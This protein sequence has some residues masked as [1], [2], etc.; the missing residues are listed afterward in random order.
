MVTLLLPIIFLIGILILQVFTGDLLSASN[1]D[2]LVNISIDGK[3]VAVEDVETEKNE[4][5]LI[6][7]AKKKTLLEIPFD[8]SVSIKLLNN[9]NEPISIEERASEGFDRTAFIDGIEELE[10]QETK[11][12]K[13][14]RL[15]VID[16]GD[17]ENKK[18][19]FLLLDKEKKQRIKIER[20]TSDRTE[21]VV[22]NAKKLEVKQPILIFNDLSDSMQKVEESTE[23]KKTETTSAEKETKT[24]QNKQPISKTTTSSVLKEE[25]TEDS[26][27]EK[28]AEESKSENKTEQ[29][30]Q[31]KESTEKSTKSEE[32]P[33]LPK[34]GEPESYDRILAV[35]TS[36][37][38]AS[39]NELLE[40]EYKPSDSLKKPK[41]LTNSK[42][43]K[44]SNGK[45]K[46]TKTDSPIIIKDVKLEVKTGTSG[47]DNDNEPGHD[48]DDENNIV[49]SFDQVSYLVSFSIQ[50][51]KQ[52]TKY[53]N[54]RYRVIGKLDNAVEIENGVPKNNGEIANGEYFEKEDD[55]QAQYSQ[56]GME[57]IITD[58]G[59]VFVPIIMTVSGAKHGKEL[60]PTFK[61][62]IV[63]AKNKETGETETFNKVYEK[64]HF[65]ALDDEKNKKITVKVSA[66]PSVKVKLVA[67]EILGANTVGSAN[68]KVGAYDVG[69]MTFLQPLSERDVGDYRGSTFPTG[70][71]N[72]TI[73][74][75]NKYYKT[76]KEN[77][78]D[79]IITGE[80]TSSQYDPMT[81][82]GSAPAINDRTSASWT[83][84]AG[85]KEEDFK[86]P[87]DIP[88]G[89]TESIHTTQPTGDLS[90]IGVYNSGNFT[91]GATTASGTPIT[92]SSYAGI[93]N[94][95]TY[96]MNGDRM[97][98]ATDKSFSS[99]ELIYSF[100]K[101]KSDAASL[102]QGW[103][104]YDMT[105]Y[106]DKIE[107]DGQT[108]VPRPDAKGEDKEYLSG[109]TYPNSIVPRGAYV[110]GPLFTKANDPENVTPEA[111]T[112]LERNHTV[113]NQNFGDARL[114]KGETIY[115]S[116]V[117]RTENPA[118]QEMKLILMW[119][120]LAFEYDDEKEILYHTLPGQR[121]F[122]KVK[123]RYGVAKIEDTKTAPYT[124]NVDGYDWTFNNIYDW[125][126]TAAEAKAKGKIAAIDTVATIDQQVDTW[127]INPRIPVKVIGGPG[128]KTPAPNSRPIGLFET[129]QFN[130]KEGETL[131]DS[132]G[133]EPGKFE[134]YKPTIYDADGTG[135]TKDMFNNWHG[136]SAYIKKFNITTK[137]EVENSVY[138]SSDDIGIT[139]TGVMSGSKDVNYDGSLTTTL[140]KGIK[141][142]EEVSS[143]CGSEPEITDNPDG[144]QTLVWE[145][146]N[147]DLDE[148]NAIEIKFLATSDFTQLT[149]KNT[150][151]T[152]NLTVNTVGRMFVAG[153]K[154]EDVTIE[155]LR[156]SK[157]TFIEH[158]VQQVVLSKTG[159]KPSIEVGEVKESA[160]PVKID[161]SITYNVK[162]VNESID[163]IKNARILEVL[164]YDGDSRG[165]KFNGSYTVE[166][167]KVV[168]KDFKGNEVKNTQ[169]KITFTNTKTEDTS[170]PNGISGWTDYIPG[171]TNVADIKNAKAFLVSHPNVDVGNSLEL[172]VK[173]RPK[174]QLA[175]DVLVNRASMDSLLE[176]PVE[177]QSV[178]TRVYGR[179][180]SGYVWYDDDYD[181]LIDKKADGSLKDPVGNIA[182]KLYRTSQED[183]SY[184][185][186]LVKQSLTRES[187]IDGSGNS[188]IKTNASGWYEFK[189]LPEGEYIAE[190]M[191]GDMVV[192]KK[193]AIVT[194]QLV[195]SDMTLN[196]KADPAS[197][198]RT[199]EK[200]SDGKPFYA[201]P[202]LKD[203]PALLTG[204]EKVHHITDVNAGLTRLSRIKLFKYEE[205]TVIDTNGDGKFSDEEIEKTARPLK[206]AEFKLYKDDPEDE[207]NLIGEAKVTGDNGWI[208]FDK[209][210]PGKY[211]VKET[212]A[213]EDFELLTEPIEVVVPTYNHTAVLHVANKGP[214]Q[215]HPT[216]LPFTGGTKAMRIVLI[217]SA[218]LLVIGMSGVL[219][220]FRPT[221]VKGGK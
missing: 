30:K 64:D 83:K 23:Q 122:M 87:L 177:S 195:G 155:K 164:P 46:A 92:N 132:A 35:E 107:Y 99:L 179:D 134:T 86:I 146:K 15:L 192:A 61:L 137:T 209:L 36:K 217:A 17:K 214:D 24:S 213:P 26:K 187:F 145:Y 45:S 109:I 181:G 141:Y 62:E 111:F 113:T 188:E 67:G 163:P 161:N 56:G 38:K 22:Q 59:Q 91:R 34:I 118:G 12:L 40:K 127:I 48:K 120:P 94:P 103:H 200:K 184:K 98:A 33:N 52:L 68:G 74:S 13:E 131:H 51:T 105:L 80:M 136:T 104:R 197:P 63:D 44:T 153:S 128:D 3:E 100:D 142:K 37:T 77:G 148:G 73:K 133:P 219:L 21:I 203:L 165:T 115:F 198:F 71:I 69:V 20:N 117:N 121:K 97:Q 25:A 216:K 171:T 9:K 168:E 41:Y 162:L 72:Y 138:N 143:N 176:L 42:E 16:E 84:N 89:L 39:L 170:K 1:K 218:G 82:V 220:H 18:S 2:S 199:P 125:Y 201:H 70:P 185:K 95:Y 159:D 93:L 5:E 19:L 116:S 204:S 126:S 81:V 32:K 207:A 96:T 55:P 194:K 180:L 66:R 85:V 60:T 174:N 183:G 191:V 7:E 206:G 57:S 79:K 50:N 101:T 119:N 178:W 169:A 6:L 106:I 210:P 31:E 14:S 124:M 196:S 54:I 172:I 167:V 4:V 205:G 65:E 28:V 114:N 88:N 75:K 150:G 110:A 152:D 102:A 76:I 53:T 11:Q 208:E 151:Y 130:T 182:V 211:F 158:L 123:F 43:T 149:F 160:D 215:Q 140:P 154:I 147:K 202:E 10:G 27:Q 90:K 221:K 144:T 157:A 112:N 47:F 129:S 186:Q 29:S 190:F 166:D 108:T 173:I 135:E 175:G 193:V 58:T 49:R 156:S 8:N 78:K 189:N 212:K 139:V